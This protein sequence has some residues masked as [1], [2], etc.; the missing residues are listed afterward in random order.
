[1]KLYHEDKLSID[2][3]ISKYLPWFRSENDKNL[4][5]V[6]IRHLLTHSSGVIRDGKT[7]HW[8]T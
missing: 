6:R 5:Q 4:Q 3:R 1:M 8:T 2:D 7:A